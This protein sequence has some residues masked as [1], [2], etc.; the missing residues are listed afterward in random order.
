MKGLEIAKLYFEQFGLPMLKEQFPEVLPYL[1]AGLT[2]SGSECFGFDDEVSRD[3]DFEPGFCIF[4]PGE[5]IVDRRTAFQLERAYAK[6]PKEFMGLQRAMLQPVGGPRHG[7]FRTAE[8]F[9]DKIG[10]P[11]TDMRTEGVSPAGPDAAAAEGSSASDALANALTPSLWLQLPEYALAEAVNGEIFLDHYGEIT[12]IRETLQTWPEDVCLKKLA[13]H[14]LLMGQSGQYNYR[15]CV[16]HGENAAAQLAV[17]EFVKSTMEVIFL[18]NRQ[19]QPYYKW[20]FR[21]LRAL[22]LLSIEAELLE[23]LLTTDN[24][25]ALAE[26][27]Y[28]VIEGIASD[29][30]DELMEQGLTKANC[31]DL[32]K[33]AYSVNDGIGDPSLRNLHVLAAV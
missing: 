33:H 22:P 26:E 25:A 2:G 21:A 19:Y 28:D 27:K 24:E 23:F 1:A 20:S 7:V 30:I 32:E 17:C 9:R 10:V 5:D 18:L 11:A 8:Y 29:I 12:A 31:G 3:H 16:Q 6:L 15:R 14:L 4:L 13:G